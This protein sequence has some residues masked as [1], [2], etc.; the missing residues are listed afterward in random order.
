MENFFNKKRT[1]KIAEATY[2]FGGDEK[3]TQILNY[4][5]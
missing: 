4:S 1:E 2:L 5:A 3:I